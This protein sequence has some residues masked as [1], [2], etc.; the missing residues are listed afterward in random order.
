MSTTTEEI[1]AIEEGAARRRAAIRR[2]MRH[3]G[4]VIGAVGIAAL[5]LAA[6]LAPW[7]APHSPT[8][9]DL[10]NTL[11]EPSA[12]YWLGTDQFG[13]CVLSRLI[14][15]AQVSLQV[16]FFV[17]LISLSAGT[18]LGAVAGY[19]GGW[20]ERAL[21]AVIDILLA[22]PSFLLALA[23]VAARGNTLD[24]IIVAV[25]IA[26]TP[27]V[28]AVM[29][30]VVLTIRPR[31]FI[32]A[33]RAIGLS[34]WQIVTRHV[35]PNALPPVIVVATVSAATAI[36]AEAGLS[37]LG[38]GVQPPTPTWGNVIAEGQTSITTRPLISLSAGL[39]IAFTVV[40]LNLLGD[41]LRDT[42]DP[43]MRRSTGK[44]L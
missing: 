41:G 37:F 21:V 16:G 24:S 11:A 40:V 2:Y 14:H 32:E 23:L 20:V 34:P 5:V 27:R 38:L 1:E 13:R 36:L 43:Q 19:A 10:M 39:C 12:T 29:R 35:I 44:L 25:A 8:R 22:F 42:L 18:I 28:A 33:S 26:Y 7:I 15:G 4:F 3:P 31:P 6:L 9:T 30:S 17:V